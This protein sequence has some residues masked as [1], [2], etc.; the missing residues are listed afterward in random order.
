MPKLKINLWLSWTLATT[1]GELIGFAV[2]TIVGLIA[3]ALKTNEIAMIPVMAIAGMGEGACFAFAQW[4]VLRKYIKNLEKRFITNTA[5][6]AGVAW[7]IGML[8]SA[9]GPRSMFLPKIL[10]AVIGIAIAA[11]FLLSI[12]YA[13]W[14]VLRKYIQKAGWWIA[15]NAIAWPLGVAMTFIPITLVPD[16]S[17]MFL[18]VAA[19][20]LGGIMMGATVG[21]IT[22][23]FLGKLLKS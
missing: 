3:V 21:A 5:I 12:G 9:I 11:V 14:L 20:I 13:Q 2:P 1:V 23:L 10:L 16:N 6:A 15:A 8:P 4:L 7:T 22:G 19:G 18:W 17:P